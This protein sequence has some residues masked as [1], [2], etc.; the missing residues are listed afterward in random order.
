[1]GLKVGRPAAAGRRQAGRK[2]DESRGRSYVKV[3]SIADD[4]S[5]WQTYGVFNKD[6]QK[7]ILVRIKRYA[8]RQEKVGTR[9]FYCDNA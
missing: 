2:P 8:E 4:S 7:H 9:A 1:M 6:W 3:T 5:S